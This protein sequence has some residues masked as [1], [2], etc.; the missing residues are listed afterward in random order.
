MNLTM[1]LLQ[2]LLAVGFLAIGWMKV[3]NYDKFKTQAGGKALGKR[4]TA[5]IGVSEIAGA[6]GLIV[7]WATGVY[8]ALTPV[9]AAAL[10]FVMVLAVGYHIQRRDPV[11]KVVPA[12]VLFGL[13][14]F[15]AWGRA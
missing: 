10:A 3:F 14:A 7:P 6:L 15:V 2:G 12:L 11:S 4:L 9:A 1:W 13:T 8:V 5:F